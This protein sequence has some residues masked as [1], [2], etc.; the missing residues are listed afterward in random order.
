MR[1]FLAYIGVISIWSTTPLAIKWSGEGPGFLFAVTGRM[2]IGALC[3]TLL[4]CWRRRKLP[5]DRHAKQ[6]Y[7]AV[8]LQIYGTMMVVY[9]STQFIPSGWVSVVFGLSPLITALLSAVMLQDQQ[10]SVLK[11][12]AYALGLFGLLLMFGSAIELDR[13]A[14]FGISGIFIGV[15][16][17]SFSA[18][19]VKLVNAKIPAISQV[20]GGL[21]VSVPLYL[22]TWG[23]VDGQWPL[24]LTK[25]SVLSIIYLGVVAT[26]IGFVLYYYLLT[27]QQATHVALITLV[28][29]VFSL[30]LGNRLNAE[31]LTLKIASGTGLILTALVLHEF[32]TRSLRTQNDKRRRTGQQSSD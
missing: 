21:L 13:H 31:P 10:L 14:L 8:A 28:T 18:V 32:S 24:I 12:C 17:Q 7:I 25:T 9:W 19:L 11:V 6:T 2:L 26:C 22:L 5:W 29:P 15:F 30:L 23:L 3:I 27:H 16:L 4:L 1:V 20:A